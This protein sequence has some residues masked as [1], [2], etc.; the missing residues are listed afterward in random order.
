MNGIVITSVAGNYK[1]MCGQPDFE[2]ITCKPKGLFRL[3]KISPCIGDFVT[4]E[5]EGGD[6]VIS[7]IA[8]R[9]NVLVRPPLANLDCGVIVVSSCEP[10]PNAL[11]IDRL[12]VILENQGIEPV[13]VFTKLDKKAADLA[14]VYEGAGFTC[15]ESG[16]LA[17]LTGFLGGKTSALIGNSGVGKTTLLNALVPGI[18]AATGEISRKLGRGRHTTRTVALYELGA[19]GYLADTPGFSTVVTTSYG[20]L[21]PEDVALYFREFVPL[22]GKCKF[23]GCTHHG[24]EGCV[25]PKG[26]SRYESYL[27]IYDEAKKAKDDW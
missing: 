7:E 27:A 22:I 11:V 16:D 6:Y 1:V 13:F 19:S 21:L 17:R 18:E 9:R 20:E 25:F 4:V 15:F 24:E 2:L 26:G 14:A 5:R 12:T 8:P 23:G 3:K 10:R